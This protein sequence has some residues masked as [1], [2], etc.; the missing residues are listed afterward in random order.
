MWPGS[1]RKTDKD[2][3]VQDNKHKAVSE[4]NAFEAVFYIG[5]HSPAQNTPLKQPAKRVYN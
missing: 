1:Y 4:A 5:M 3:P 2:L